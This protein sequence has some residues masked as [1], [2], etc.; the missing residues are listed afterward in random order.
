MRSGV[1]WKTRLS[2]KISNLCSLHRLRNSSKATTSISRLQTSPSGRSSNDQGS[3]RSSSRRFISLSAGR[4]CR[5]RRQWPV[6]TPLPQ[7]A[8][9]T[10]LRILGVRVS[11]LRVQPS[12]EKA[13]ARYPS[14]TSNRTYPLLGS[15]YLPSSL[16]RLSQV[17]RAVSRLINSRFQIILHRTRSLS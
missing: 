11:R 8:V 3:M 17:A 13:M 14:H 12:L 6:R 7:S 9:S 10:A 1:T 5:S 15:T 16:V 2:S 4:R